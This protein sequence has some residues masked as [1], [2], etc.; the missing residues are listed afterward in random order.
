MVV[1]TMGVVI[2]MVILHDRA[3]W[4]DVRGVTTL[5]GRFHVLLLFSEG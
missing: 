3:V 4:H 1:R 2:V 5:F